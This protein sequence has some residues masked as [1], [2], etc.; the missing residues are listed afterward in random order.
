M[1]ASVAEC[2]HR[3]ILRPHHL[4]TTDETAAASR[5]RRHTR[6]EAPWPVY[7]PSRIGDAPG[8]RTHQRTA[9][10]GIGALKE[11][12]QG[13]ERLADYAQLFGTPADRDTNGDTPPKLH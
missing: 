6:R 8:P 1:S 9:L 4:I 5:C 11:G 3:K 2:R 7:P 12:G 13:G 10:R